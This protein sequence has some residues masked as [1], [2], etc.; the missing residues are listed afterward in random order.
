MD[1]IKGQS[2]AKISIDNPGALNLSIRF[3]DFIMILSVLPDFLSCLSL[4]VSLNTPN[5]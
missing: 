1:V 4:I 3:V 5:P 2:S